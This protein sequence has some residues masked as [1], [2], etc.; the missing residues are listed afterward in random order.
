M[1][2]T[3]PRS[4][5]QGGLFFG[6]FPV[7]ILS[8]SSF[9]PNSAT[10]RLPHLFFAASLPT[11]KTPCSRPAAPPPVLRRAVHTA[12]SATSS[13]VH[14]SFCLYSALV[15]IWCP[16]P[17]PCTAPPLPT[18]HGQFHPCYG[19]CPDPPISVFCPC[20]PLGSR[21]FSHHHYIRLTLSAHL[22]CLFVPFKVTR[23]DHPRTRT[24]RNLIVISPNSRIIFAA[25]AL[26]T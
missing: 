14:F 1:L 12:A 11:T 20:P 4:P 13:P 21:L 6:L 25:G 26:F 5:P 22:C 15:V 10:D 2:A 8:L 16:Y 18:R 7:C 3:P 24:S 9:L 23:S 17:P 19:S